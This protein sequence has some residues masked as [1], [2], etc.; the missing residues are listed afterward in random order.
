MNENALAARRAALEARRAKLSEAQQAVLEGR[1][2]GQVAPMVRRDPCVVSLHEGAGAPLFLVHP[3]G[4][5]VLCFAALARQIGD[6]TVYGLQS[7]GFAGEREPFTTMQEIGAHFVEAIRQVQPTGP[8]RL[9]G[10]SLGAQ[11]AFEIAHQLTAAG[12]DVEF[13]GLIDGDPAAGPTART[14]LDEAA[15]ADNASWLDGIV[16]YLEQVWGRSLAVST[17]ALA[18][19]APNAQLEAFVR[20]LDEAKVEVPHATVPSVQQLRRVLAV[21]KANMRALI[22]YELKVYPGPMTLI[23]GDEPAEW[24]TAARAQW[25]SLT[26]RELVVRETRGDHYSLMASPQVEG[27]GALLGS[28][29]HGGPRGRT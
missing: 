24:T 27:L 28:L 2:A 13:L 10:W 15:F 20:A 1:L 19:L 29:L 3:A 5:D 23:L 22:A 17:K 12:H 16:R 14:S 7:P 26:T 4:G 6:R 18:G 9:A 21:Y 11:V 25:A 8:Y